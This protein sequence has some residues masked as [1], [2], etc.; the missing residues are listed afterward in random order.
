MHKRE[1]RNGL[2]FCNISDVEF[3]S[4]L[5]L[6]LAGKTQHSLLDDTTI[7]E[8]LVFYYDLFSSLGPVSD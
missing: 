1:R 8:Q 3:Y 7:E 2:S 4:W 6:T 5:S